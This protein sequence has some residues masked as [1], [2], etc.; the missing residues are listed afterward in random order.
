MSTGTTKNITRTMLSSIL[1]SYFLLK[2]PLRVYYNTT[3]NEKFGIHALEDL[4]DDVSAPAGQARGIVTNG[5]EC[6]IQGIVAGM[7]GHTM[8]M[9]PDGNTPMTQT[10]QHRSTD[11]SLFRHTPMALKDIAAGEDLK[12]NF[13]QRDK[14]FLRKERVVDGK[15]Y[16]AYYG[17]RLDTSMIEPV[18]NVLHI[19]NDIITSS[20]PFEFDSG[21]LNPSAPDLP[22]D[23]LMTSDAE[24][25]AITSLME[26]IFNESV[27]AEYRNAAEILYGT[28]EMAIC[29][30]MGVV[31]GVEKSFASSVSGDAAYKEVLNAQIITHMCSY[32]SLANSN[33]GF[34]TTLKLG[35]TEPVLSTST[36]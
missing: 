13:P 12:T 33:A 27:A 36:I 31:T 9:G 20:T 26:V 22:V 24:Y 21:N 4:T 5:V 30:E 7:G 18:I 1:H 3:L 14:Y 19:E 16:A 17:Y 15:T 29:S 10:V 34:K 8:V 2:K 35:A 28:T 23:D 32:Q 11:F 25:I 6:T